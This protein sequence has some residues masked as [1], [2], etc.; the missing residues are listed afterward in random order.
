LLS[1]LKENPILNNDKNYFVKLS[2]DVTIN[3]EYQPFMPA[4]L[5]LC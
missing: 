5:F 1:E 3:L 2:F 4:F